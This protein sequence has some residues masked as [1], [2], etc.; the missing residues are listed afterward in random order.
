M[1]EIPMKPMNNNNVKRLSPQE[2]RTLLLTNIEVLMSE[3]FKSKAP[4]LTG[5]RKVTKQSSTKN[6]L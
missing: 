6:S 4:E 1:R 3:R 2:M 5:Q